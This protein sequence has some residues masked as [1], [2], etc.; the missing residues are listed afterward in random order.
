VVRFTWRR[1]RDRPA[2][3]AATLRR[4]LAGSGLHRSG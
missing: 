2:E 4:L 3:V 1:L